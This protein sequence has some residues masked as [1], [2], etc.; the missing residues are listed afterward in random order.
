MTFYEIYCRNPRALRQT[1]VV[2]ED[3][4]AYAHL[5]E[6]VA[7]H[8]RHLHSGIGAVNFDQGGLHRV[9]RAASCFRYRRKGGNL[10]AEQ[11]RTRIQIGMGGIRVTGVTPKCTIKNPIVV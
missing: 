1:E 9:F 7:A 4:V 11:A 5:V 8:R 2:N 3:G 10:E 6:G